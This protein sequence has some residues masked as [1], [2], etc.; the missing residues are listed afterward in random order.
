MNVVK[1]FSKH[2]HYIR[3]I[4]TRFC[5]FS[6]RNVEIFSSVEKFPDKV[7]SQIIFYKLRFNKKVA[8]KLNLPLTHMQGKPISD[9]AV[10]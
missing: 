9:F 10:I 4:A 3:T 6:C 2:Q 1:Y 5:Y 7:K 8:D